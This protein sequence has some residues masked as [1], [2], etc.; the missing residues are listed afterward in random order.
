[1]SIAGGSACWSPHLKRHFTP[2]SSRV[3]CATCGIVQALAIRARLLTCHSYGNS[4]VRAGP[5]Q[6]GGLALGATGDL[7]R[8]GRH[9]AAGSAP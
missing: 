8:F 2:V 9:T 1:M 5:E 4:L 7:S 3:C 6:V